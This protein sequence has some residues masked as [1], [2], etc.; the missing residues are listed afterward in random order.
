MPS[1]V[2]ALMTPLMPGAGPPPTRMA[3]LPLVVPVAILFGQQI[4]NE[5]FFL[6]QFIDGH[7][8]FC[9]AEIVEQQAL[10]DFEFL[11]VAAN[12]KGTD[13]ALLDSIAAVGASAE[14][15]PVPV[16]RRFQD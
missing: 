11:P 14:A 9:A 8:D 2:A 13:E 1:M 7:G 4:A 15:M 3:S 6:L 16:A 5:R 12:R 10:H